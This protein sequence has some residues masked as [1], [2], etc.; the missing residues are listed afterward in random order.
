MWWSRTWNLLGVNTVKKILLHARLSQYMYLIP[1]LSYIYRPWT[2]VIRSCAQRSGAFNWSSVELVSPGNPT[3]LA[4][5]NIWHPIYHTSPYKIPLLE[6]KNYE[7]LLGSIIITWS[8]FH[9]PSIHTSKGIQFYTTRSLYSL[10]LVL[11]GTYIRGIFSCRSFAPT[12]LYVFGP[13]FVGRTFTPLC[14][15]VMAFPC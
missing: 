10:H 14:T 15:T 5:D 8:H 4:C 11:G 9:F 2:L 3:S 7:T 6:H 1:K 12:Q 13:W